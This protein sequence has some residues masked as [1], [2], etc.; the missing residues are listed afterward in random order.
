MAIEITLKQ[1]RTLRDEAMAAGDSRMVDICDVALCSRE[2][3]NDDGTP[4]VDSDGRPTTRTAAQVECARVIAEAREAS[5]VTVTAYGALGFQSGCQCGWRS[6]TFTTRAA[7]LTAAR[8]HRA[9]MR[10]QAL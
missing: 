5:H 7:A 4:L 2:S 9:N 10:V 8:M 1:I 6:D 3:A